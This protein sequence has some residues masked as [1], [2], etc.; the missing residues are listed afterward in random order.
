MDFPYE[1][2]EDYTPEM[3][4]Y[5]SPSLYLMEEDMKNEKL[6]RNLRKLKSSISK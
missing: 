3:S 2:G 6:L 4:A 5:G 1:F